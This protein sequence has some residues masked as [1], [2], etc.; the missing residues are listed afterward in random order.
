MAFSEQVER[1]LHISQQT[2]GHA[3]FGGVPVYAYK[4]SIESPLPIFKEYSPY[5]E[6]FI[7]R[8]KGIQDLYGVLLYIQKHASVG[9]SSST[10][11]QNSPTTYTADFNLRGFIYEGWGNNI[12][13]NLINTDRAERANSIEEAKICVEKA[14]SFLQGSWEISDEGNLIGNN[15]NYDSAPWTTNWRYGLI[16]TF[17]PYHAAYFLEYSLNKNAILI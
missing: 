7:A 17:H 5:R 2:L 4:N 1:I 10:W 3:I 9:P 6:R 16:K 8:Y 15:V 14:C 12:T 13:Y 11:N